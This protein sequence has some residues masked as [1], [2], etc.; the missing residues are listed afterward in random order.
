MSL[1]K[2]SYKVFYE[3]LECL[4]K[5][6]AAIHHN[7]SLI[8]IKSTKMSNSTFYF[9]PKGLQSFSAQDQDQ[10]GS[11]RTLVDSEAIDFVCNQS[12]L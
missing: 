5:R 3:H 1:Y 12:H 8:Q 2:S 6:G 9:L 4:S 11:Q 10:C 7:F